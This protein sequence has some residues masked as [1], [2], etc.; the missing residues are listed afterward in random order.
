M[1]VGGTHGNEVQGVRGVARVIKYLKNPTNELGAEIL[2][3]STVIAVPVINGVGY[4]A[5]A[6]TCPRMQADPEVVFSEGKVWVRDDE[7]GSINPP[8][9]WSDPGRGWE[10]ND[11]FV[12]HHLE[13]LLKFNPSVIL[14]NHDW[15]PPQGSL[16]YYGDKIEET[17]SAGVR[18]I[19]RQFYPTKT[20][21]GKDWKFCEVASISKDY[22]KTS[23][24]L[25]QKFGIP[26]Y[27]IENYLFSERSADIH[28]V[29]SL[30]LLAKHAGVTW[31][32][33]RLIAEIFKDIN[34]DLDW[35]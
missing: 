31:D 11:T 27:T 2:T 13:Q 22:M 16:K 6:R 20:I 14:F 23:W 25:W 29:V 7:K 18:Q 35:I 12:K 9:G 28:T 21:F 19:F 24:D 1:I 30:F 26:N 15:A 32:D 8:K 17:I 4:V 5:G 3:K 33:N 34:P 10:K